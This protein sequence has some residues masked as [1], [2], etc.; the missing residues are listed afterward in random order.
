MHEVDRTRRIAE[1]MK[2]ELATIISHDL[3]DGRINNVTITAVTVSRDLKQS[4][5]YFSSIEGENDPKTM[6]K[7][8]NKSAS[9]LRFRLS[10]LLEMRTTPA[11]TFKYD[12]SLKRG[13]EMSTL[14]E[15][16]NNRND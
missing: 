4:T 13:M 15:K 6:E 10:K 8:L 1:L 14:I 9:F 2:R 12:G 11:I 7:L 3:N 5:A 16:L